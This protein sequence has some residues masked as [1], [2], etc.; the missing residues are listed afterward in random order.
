MTK[1]S[2]DK[3]GS[4]AEVTADELETKGG[5]GLSVA[6]ITVTGE[7]GKIQRFWIRLYKTNKLIKCEVSACRP[8]L[9]QDVRSSVTGAW[10]QPTQR[11]A[12][13]K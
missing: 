12:S 13:Q 4:F 9:P 1:F 3:F 10:F 8:N 2:T 6:E 11:T 7:D 5:H